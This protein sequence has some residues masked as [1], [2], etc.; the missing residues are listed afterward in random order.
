M[1]PSTL[2]KER[3]FSW[4]NEQEDARSIPHEA[5]HSLAGQ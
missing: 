5:P 1:V 4:P 2:E 3:A